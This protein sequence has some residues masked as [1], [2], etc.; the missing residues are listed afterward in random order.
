METIIRQCKRCEGTGK[1]V[2]I[3]AHASEQKCYYCHGTGSFSDFSES[4]IINL[5]IS[6]KGKNKG[7]LRASMTSTNHSDGLTKNRS[8]YVWRMAR[9]HG[10][11][12]TTMPIMAQL[13]VRYDPYI[14][15]LD[16]LADKIASKYF[17]SNMRAARLWGRALG[18]VE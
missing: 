14:K 15:E 17:G 12:D 1:F 10:G 13:C 8:Y 16:L 2:D 5:I 18:M 4:D 9:F 7:K 11:A 6:S 3:Y